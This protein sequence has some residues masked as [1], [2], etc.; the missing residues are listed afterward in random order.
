LATWLVILEEVLE[1][2]RRGE[3]V[4]LD[5]RRGN[6]EDA[7]VQRLVEMLWLH[8]VDDAIVDV[9]VHQD[10]AAEELLLGLDIVRHRLCRFTLCSGA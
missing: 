10:R 9:V 5:A 7:L 2:H 8:D 4:L 1:R 3:V 6:L